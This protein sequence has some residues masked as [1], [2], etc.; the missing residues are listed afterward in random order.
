MLGWNQFEKWKNRIMVSHQCMDEN[1]RIQN[2]FQH[3][4][5]LIVLKGTRYRWPPLGEHIRIKYKTII[6]GNKYTLIMTGRAKV[7]FVLW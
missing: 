7:F 6:T 1:K 2:S 4:H 5:F 3:R